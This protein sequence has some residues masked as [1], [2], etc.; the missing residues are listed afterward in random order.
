MTLRGTKPPSRQTGFTTILLT[1]TIATS[2]R[3]MIGVETMPP[4]APSEV[5]VMVEPDSSSRA[6]TPCARRLAHPAHFARAFVQAESLGVADDRNHE[7]VRRLRRHAHMHGAEAR[8]DVVF[9]VVM[10][11][12]LR[13]LGDRLDDPKDEERQQGQLR[14]LFTWRGR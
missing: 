2:G 7:A 3:L 8:D 13:E 4:S 6:A 5:S 10:R 12:D 9:V 14:P 11:V 1:P